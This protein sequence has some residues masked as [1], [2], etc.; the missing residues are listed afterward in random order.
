LSD[1]AV[2]VDSTIS[3]TG[4]NVESTNLQR[5]ALSDAFHCSD[6]NLRNSAADPS[7]AGVQQEALEA[8]KG[9]LALWEAT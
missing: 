3:A 9:W 2:I 8:M 7:V 6:L 5:I 4:L 1:V